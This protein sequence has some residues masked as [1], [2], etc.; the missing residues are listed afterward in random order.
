MESEDE[1]ERREEEEEEKNATYQYSFSFYPSQRFSS[2][3]SIQYNLS[4]NFN[5]HVHVL[6]LLLSCARE[7]VYRS[8][9]YAILV[10]IDHREV[11][12]VIKMDR[13]RLN[14]MRSRRRE[15]EGEKTSVSRIL[16]GP[17]NIFPHQ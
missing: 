6:F 1:E 16:Y 13:K 2:G 15:R 3:L 10:Y 12:R 7:V 14:S 11:K 4:L 8:I 5:L 17:V 9:R